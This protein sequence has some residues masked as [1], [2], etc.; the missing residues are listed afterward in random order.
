MSHTIRSSAMTWH[1]GERKVQSLLHVPPMDYPVS[2]GLSPYAARLLQMC[3]MVAIGTL[4]D[5]DQPWTTLLGR[6][7]GFA[8]FLGQSIIGLKTLVDS[9]YDPVVQLL[10]GGKP[11]GE[12]NEMGNNGRLMSGLGIHLEA[13]E[14]VKFAGRAV[15]TSVGDSTP[16]AKE[17][18]DCAVEMQAV[19]AISQSMGEYLR[20]SLNTIMLMCF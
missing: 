5:H 2:P 15:A 14:R 17:D 19:F 7:P 6:E 11:Y 10:M 12:V 18:D 4:D 8:R 3:S 9:K 16:E 1:K 20:G 13:R